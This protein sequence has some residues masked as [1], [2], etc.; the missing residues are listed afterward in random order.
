M[1]R[2]MYE[3]ETQLNHA[4]LYLAELERRIKEDKLPSG[5][6]VRHVLAS[7]NWK[8]IIAQLERELVQSEFDAFR[9]FIEAVDKVKVA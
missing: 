8:Q 6:F 1:E 4:K 5:Q 2:K 3:I 7:W 9:D